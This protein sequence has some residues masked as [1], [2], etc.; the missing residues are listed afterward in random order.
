MSRDHVARESVQTLLA[1]AN[2]VLDS[3]VT[4]SWRDSAGRATYQAIVRTHPGRE[5][6]RSLSRH[7]TSRSRSGDRSRSGLP[8]KGFVIGTAVVAASVAAGLVISGVP[9]RLLGTTGT[10]R[11][12]T[13]I[14][15]PKL[16]TRSITWPAST[17]KSAKGTAPMLHYTLTGIVKPGNTFES[18]TARSVLLKL[19]RAAEHRAPLPQPPG[20]RISFVVTNDWFLDSSTGGGKTSSVITP[21]VNDT[22]FAPNGKSRVLSRQGH[23]VTVVD[24]SRQTLRSL[25]GGPPV[26]SDRFPAEPENPVVASLSLH[27]AALKREL[28][29]ADPG[30]QPLSYRLVDTIRML[31]EQIVSP[32]LDA[33]MWRV[34]AARPD[35]SY[36]GKVTDRAGRSGVAVAFSERSGERLVLIISP[37]TGQLL[38]SED[39]LLSGAPALHLTAYPA[40]VGYT[41]F[42]DQHWAKTMNGSGK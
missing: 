33:A 27:P 36:L 10:T 8:R 24:G 18:P 1:D 25:Q 19:A 34:L 35:L 7:A 21:Q 13:G 17:A 28:L 3:A 20:A 12:P 32:R 26:S 40:V 4:D 16:P 5:P 30:G 37:S 42:V 14:T 2:P 31:H 38:G 23:P 22:W 15:R 39:L 9:S 29:H 6:G 11:P 41:I